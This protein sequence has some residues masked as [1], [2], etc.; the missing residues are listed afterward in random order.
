M[1]TYTYTYTYAFTYTYIYIL[2][3]HIYIYVHLSLWTQT[4][5]EKIV[6]SPN[7]TSI[8]PYE[9]TWIHMVYIYID[10]YM[11]VMLC[12]LMLCYV[13][14]KPSR[15]PRKWRS[16]MRMWAAREPL[17]VTWQREPIILC[18]L[19]WDSLWMFMG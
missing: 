4:P 19:N 6:N 16:A 8:T 12:Y 9:G 18:R 15:L 2:Y 1:Y 10:I 17:P 11:K 5:P 7:H 3:L 13:R 14:Q